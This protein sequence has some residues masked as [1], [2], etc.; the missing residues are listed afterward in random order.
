MFPCEIKD[1]ASRYTLSIRFRAAVQDL[2]VHFG[3]VYDQ[4][5][6]YIGELGEHHA[7]AAFAIYYNMDMQDLDIE[8]GFP[9]SGPLPGKGEIQTG[10]IEGG[11]FAVCHYTGPYNEVS[12]AYEDLTQFVQAQGYV[13]NGPAYE[14]YLNGPDVPPQKL[15]TDL[16]LP[17]KRMEETAE[18]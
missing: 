9:V 18:A 5:M 8:A 12:A 4:V 2:P 13:F 11:Q 16:T 6:R 7:G 3:R 14:W 15:R 17:V 1:E 10:S